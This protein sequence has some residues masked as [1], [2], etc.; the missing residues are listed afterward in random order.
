MTYSYRRQ[1]NFSSEN[2]MSVQNKSKATTAPTFGT[3]E[4]WRTLAA[5]PIGWRPSI[6]PFSEPSL[7]SCSPR[8]LVC[9]VWNLS[10][11]ITQRQGCSLRASRIL[12]ITVANTMS[13]WVNIFC[14]SHFCPF[15]FVLVPKAWEFWISEPNRAQSIEGFPSSWAKKCQ[16]VQLSTYSQAK[17]MVLQ[18]K[19]AS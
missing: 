13:T 12:A 5:V 2:T 17:S 9:I 4:S 19:F 8:L 3:L 16:Q 18:L 7:K 10:E 1:R 15:H 11:S 6:V 14:L